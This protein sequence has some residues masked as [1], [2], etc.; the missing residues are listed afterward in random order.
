MAYSHVG[1]FAYSC[2]DYCP[3]SK[4]PLEINMQVPLPCIRAGL[5]QHPFSN[6]EASVDAGSQAENFF[7]LWRILGC[8]EGHPVTPI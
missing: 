6:L 7:K 4:Q 2:G 8:F 5:Q 1:I 3:A